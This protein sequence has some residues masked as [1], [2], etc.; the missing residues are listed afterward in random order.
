ML[1]IDVG[2]YLGVWGMSIASQRAK[3][4]EN[5]TP[6]VEVM[7]K[8]INQQK[9]KLGGAVVLL[10]WAVVDTSPSYL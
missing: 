1:S 5:R 10:G 4:H 8:T 9:L 3:E 6:N 2:T 7:S